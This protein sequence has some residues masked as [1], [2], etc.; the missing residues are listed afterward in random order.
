MA[1]PSYSWNACMSVQYTDVELRPLTQ[2]LRFLHR[3]LP[4]KL[5]HVLHARRVEGMDFPAH[6]MEQCHLAIQSTQR[7]KCQMC[8]C[9]PRNMW[10]MGPGFYIIC[11]YP[12]GFG[13]TITKVSFLL[14]M[15]IHTAGHV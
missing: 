4:W 1:K 12:D 8:R 9:V 10:P 6:K 3:K 13:C 7:Y 15:G 14:Y 2:C 11:V 5:K